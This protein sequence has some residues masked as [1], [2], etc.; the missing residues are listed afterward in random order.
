MTRP[1]RIGILAGEKSGDNLGAGLMAAIQARHPQCRFE[2][3]GGPAMIA[4]G[5]HSL[6]PME[7]LSVMG[8]IEPLGRLPELLRID[9][10][11][12]RHFIANPPDVFIGIDSPGF[13]LRFEERLRRHGIK[14]VH[15]VSPSVWA[16]GEKRILRI[17]RAVDLML[18]LFPFET[19]IYEA[20]DVPVTYVGHP[21]ADSIGP[22]S[23]TEAARQALGLAADDTVITLMPGSRGTEI[24]RL[25][26]VLLTTAR[27]L[28]MQR[29][30]L[31]LLLPC[32]GV[33]HQAPLQRLIADHGLE[34][35]VSLLD[36][37]AH[38]AIAAADVVVLA[39][40]TA[41][42]EA[43]LLKRPM[44]VCYRLSS[45]TYALASRMIRIPY[46]GLPN[47]LAGRRLVPEL[48]Q[49]DL[50]PTNLMA[51][52]N[53][54]LAGKDDREALLEEY[55]RIHSMLRCNASQQA[56]D[57]VLQLCGV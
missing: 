31:K 40:G 21:L 29:P 15:Y 32:A 20:N 4:L 33:E 19:M 45:L 3:I 41:T 57:A 12:A 8:F 53:R 18:V 56:A 22:E 37:N 34:G 46:V 55:E 48:L 38:G 6:F 52:V 54:I 28:L 47:L 11:L 17:R 13:N 16:Y 26:P 39:S 7:R 5:F 44:V 2:G 23:R 9:R 30:Q 27:Q 35:R 25:A 36:G 1:L 43:L 24:K 14:T 49:A 51:A 10:Q 42:L 50:T